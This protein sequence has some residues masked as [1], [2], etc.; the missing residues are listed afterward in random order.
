[1]PGYLPVDTPPG[2]TPMPLGSPVPANPGK[3]APVGKG[4]QPPR[5][6]GQGKGAQPSGK[7]RTHKPGRSFGRSVS[8]GS[9][10]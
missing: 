10:R 8:K 4:P 5:A 7:G 3:R 9:R 2:T 6:K 1:M